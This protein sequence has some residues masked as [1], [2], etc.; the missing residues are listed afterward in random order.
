MPTKSD[1][2]DLRVVLHSETDGAILVSED[3]DRGTAV[4]LPKSKVEFERAPPALG[5]KR[6]DVQVPQWLA[7][8]RGLV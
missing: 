1:I 2:L 7:E 6:V 4:W 5:M 8:N 3:G